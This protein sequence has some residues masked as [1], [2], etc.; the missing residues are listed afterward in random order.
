MA[1][2]APLLIQGDR[3]KKLC[4]VTCILLLNT[5]LF[6]QSHD[7]YLTPNSPEHHEQFVKNHIV[8]NKQSAIQFLLSGLDIIE[9]NASLI[10]TKIN[11]GLYG[12]LPAGFDTWQEGT[13]LQQIDHD[14]MQL[15]QQLISILKNEQATA[16]E[17]SYVMQQV[18]DFLLFIISHTRWNLCEI[19]YDGYRSA[20]GWYKNFHPDEINQYAIQKI[21]Y[22]NDISVSCYHKGKFSLLNPGNLTLAS[23]LKRVQYEELVRCRRLYI[24]IQMYVTWFY[25]IFGHNET[26]A[27][28][29]EKCIKS[30]EEAF[31]KHMKR[32]TLDHILRFD[33]QGVW[34]KLLY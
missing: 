27:S 10:Y 30:T 6:P 13:D 28:I 5:V 29:I 2:K 9:Q 33:G 25:N 31:E 32:F 24:A 21:N 20:Q 15:I 22:E 23:L 17:V 12:M 26:T 19:Q 1:V 11:N 4:I 7:E 14:I 34:A 18:Y 16:E 3:M 8:F